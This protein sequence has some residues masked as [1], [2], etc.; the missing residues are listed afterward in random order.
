MCCGW[1]AEK[2]GTQTICAICA[3]L[4]NFVGLYLRNLDMYRQSERNLL[5][6]N[7]SSRCHHNMANFSP[8]TAEIGWRVWGTP[9]NFN[10]FRVLALLLQRRRSPEANQTLHDVWPSSGLVH[11]IYTFFRRLLP[12][13][14]I[15][16]GA[17]FT[18]RPSLAFSYIGSN[19]ARHLSVCLFVQSFSQP[20]S[21]RLGSN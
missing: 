1:L 17:N 19:T 14:E 9:S 21:I 8:L 13:D 3:P 7:V 10:G 15:L 16:P 4:H 5:K 12:P 18:W 2:N 6:S 20:S 11:Y